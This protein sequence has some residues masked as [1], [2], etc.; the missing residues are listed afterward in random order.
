MVRLIRTIVCLLNCKGAVYPFYG[1][2]N[3]AKYFFYGMILG[4]A[5]ANIGMVDSPAP[6]ALDKR[7]PGRNSPR[8]SQSQLR[9]IRGPRQPLPQGLVFFL[10]GQ[11]IRKIRD[12][13]TNIQ[14]LLAAADLT[15]YDEWT[16]VIQFCQPA[17]KQREVHFA[18]TNFYFLAQ[19]VR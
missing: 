6:V 15:L 19:L 4:Q 12:R 3:R 2:L 11:E 14:N 9:I 1:F 13:L 16:L 5:T 8:R 7:A 10:A 17:E 18:G